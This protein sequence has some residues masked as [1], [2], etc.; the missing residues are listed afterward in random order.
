MNKNKLSVY[1]HFFTFGVFLILI[2]PSFL[3]E[4]MF[5]DGLWYSSIAKNMALGHGSFWIPSFSATI[6]HEFYS[7]PPLA[8]FL[9]S[10]FFRIFGY[11][12]H[13]DKLYSLFTILL[14]TFLIVKIWQHL[15]FKN[16][17]IAVFIWF[18]I[19]II[20]WTATNNM[21]ENTLTVFTTLSVL[22]FL[23]SN[24]KNK[25]FF[26]L[27]TGISITLGILSKGLVALFPIALPLFY[28]LVNK[29]NSV[30]NMLL[31]TFALVIISILPLILLYKFNNQAHIFFEN[32]YK[33]QLIKSFNYE[34][35]NTRFYI[36]FQTLLQLVFPISLILILMTLKKIKKLKVDLEF[37]NS[38]FF[39]LIAVSASLPLMISL[40]QST[41]YLIPSM[42]FF[43]ICFA[44]IINQ[45]FNLF[46]IKRDIFI[47]FTSILIVCLG[48]LLNILNFG[49]IGRDKEILTQT[50][51]IIDKLP[52][53]SIV[54]TN[55]EIC[56]N[57][58]FIAYFSR[59]NNISFYVDDKNKYEFMILNRNSKNKFVNYE[60]YF[61]TK[62][63]TIYKLSRKN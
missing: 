55:R 46:E 18:T 36:L 33:N 28:F 31:E 52:P 51:Q 9:Q 58:S 41:Q 38:I 10:F 35:V 29:N 42:P 26:I 50:H 34:N 45:F 16:A 37:K 44:I 11:S 13:I 14:T 53:N 39:L 7:H 19:P 49:K 30:W 24:D 62:N 5:L 57:Y 32:Y 8:F 48:L 27:L 2:S 40:K 47:K 4:G 25:T 1:L 15:K 59:Y 23:K 12:Y 17:W 43:S 61:E 6:N 22:F 56:T 60:Q 20:F 54:N 3:S 63:Y 21:L